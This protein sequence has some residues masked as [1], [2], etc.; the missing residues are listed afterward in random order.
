M[1]EGVNTPLVTP[2]GPGPHPDLGALKALIDFVM[3]GG[4]RA[5]CIGGTTGEFIHYSLDDR[6]RMLAC[7]TAHSKAPIIAGIAH[8]SLDGALDLARIAA[9]AG[10]SALL[11][12][13]PYFFHY[14]QEEV[15]E[16]YLRFADACPPAL[17]I[18]LY[19][20]PAFTNDISFETARGLLSSGR[21]AGIK[22]SSGSMDNFGRLRALRSHHPFTLL[23]GDDKMFTEARTQGA[24]GVISGVAGVIP[25]LMIGID[26]AVLAGSSGR[27]Q[28][29]DRRL[30]EFI[31]WL[32]RFPTP[33]GIKLALAERGLPTGPHAVPLSPARQRLAQQFQ[34]WFREWLPAVLQEAA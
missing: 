20:I 27:A 14:Q 3:A 22:D 15:R 5:I 9:E 33:V 31:A 29:L 32:D 25:E 1:L 6:Q 19:N 17:P 12:M 13:P 7:A 34:D 23:V 18:L 8:S 30:R 21:F 24:D 2:C 26:R 28:L 10:A 16:F 11:V 4:V